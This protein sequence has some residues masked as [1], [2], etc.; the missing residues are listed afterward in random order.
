MARLTG[1]PRGRNNGSI[2]AWKEC[3]IGAGRTGWTWIDGAWHRD[4]PAIARRGSHRLQSHGA[5]VARGRQ[6]YCGGAGGT[7]A[8]QVGSASDGP[9]LEKALYGNGVPR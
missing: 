4:V 7:D 9:K 5:S 2:D 6:P 8:P 3:Q 1:P